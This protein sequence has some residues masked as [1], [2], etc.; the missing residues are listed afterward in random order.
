MEFRLLGP[1][2]AITG[3]GRQTDLGPPMHRLLLAVLLAADGRPVPADTL[4]TRLWDHQPATARDLLHGYASKLRARLTTPTGAVDDTPAMPPAHEHGYR[5]PV[6]RH[7]VDAHRFH[8]A[9]A[10]ARAL[11]PGDPATTA[12]LLRQA[13][14]HW[15]PHGRVGDDLR[16]AEPLAGLGGAWAE[17][18]RACLLGEHRA[19]LLECLRAE[20]TLDRHGAIIPQLEHLARAD[21]TDETITALLLHACHQA[22]RQAHATRA[23]REHYDH[24]RQASL[25]PSPELNRLYTQILNNDPALSR[26]PHTDIARLTPPV[27]DRPHTPG[28]LPTLPATPLPDPHDHDDADSVDGEQSQRPE[29]TTD[30]GT[31]MPPSPTLGSLIGIQVNSGPGARVYNVGGRM[32]VHEAPPS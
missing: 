6:A 14:A 13:L 10:A 5:L 4:I 19:A 9:L 26:P 21:P 23:Y 11:P 20:L 18:Y 3:D 28:P 2:Q 24:L 1:V 25:V 17:D 22:G 15:H 32:T 31:A 30:P 16:P 29:P 8:D 7:Q 27:P 12:R